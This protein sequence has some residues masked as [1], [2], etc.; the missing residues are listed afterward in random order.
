M[1]YLST[2]G[3]KKHGESPSRLLTE[4]TAPELFASIAVVEIV[5]PAFVLVVAVVLQTLH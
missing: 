3:G 2:S 5:D 1:P 4:Y